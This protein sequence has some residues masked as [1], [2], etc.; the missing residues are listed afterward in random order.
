M[1]L[2]RVLL[3][4]GDATGAARELRAAIRGWREV[5]APYEVARARVVLATALRAVDDE[6]DAD[7]ELRAALDEFER[8]G[9]RD[10]RRGGRT[11]A[12]SGRGPPE[13]PVTRS[14]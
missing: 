9:A 10:R 1:A 14:G 13:G 3:A 7:L 5:G 11:R 12:S 6:D 2:G 8:L 4:E